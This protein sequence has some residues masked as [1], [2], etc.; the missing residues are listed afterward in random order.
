MATKKK[1]RKAS[2]DS[3]AEEDSDEDEE[4]EEEEEETME[5]EE[6]VGDVPKAVLDEKDHIVRLAYYTSKGNNAKEIMSLQ[7]LQKYVD[8]N[9][10]NG[11]KGVPEALIWVLFQNGEIDHDKDTEMD[12][13]TEIVS[14]GQSD[15]LLHWLK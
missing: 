10:R 7:E 2:D 13:W 5:D 11:S 3:D 4:E 8:N 14:V 15:R 1:K 6:D 9:K 12:L